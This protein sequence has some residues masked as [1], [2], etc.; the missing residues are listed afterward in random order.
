MHRLM[1]VNSTAAAAAGQPNVSCT[2]NCKRSLFQSMEITELEF[3]QIIIIVVVM[4]VMVVVITCLLSHYKLSA[5]SFISRHSQG[6]RRED[7]LSSAADG[8]CTRGGAGSRGLCC[9]LGTDAGERGRMPVALR[10]HSVRQRN[11]R[12]SQVPCSRTPGSGSLLDDRPEKAAL[13]H[14]RSASSSRRS[15]PRLGPP[16]AWPCRPSP[17]GTAST[18]SS[19]PTRTCST[20]STCPPPSRCRTGRSPHPTRA[21]APSSFGTPSSSWN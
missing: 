21:P 15:T 7:A 17:S 2:C 19:P 14:S 9:L 12:E 6:R 16:T 8:M 18:A 13:P 10:E 20:R 11:P 5:R 4:M 1:G 3:V